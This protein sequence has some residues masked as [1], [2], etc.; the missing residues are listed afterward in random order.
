MPTKIEIKQGTKWNYLTYIKDA[1]SIKIPSGQLFRCGEFKCDCGKIVNVII[2]SVKRGNTKSCGCY[3]LKLKYE[4]GKIINKK[5]NES[6]KNK[7]V[8]Y[9]TWQSMKTRCYN[10]NNPRWNRYGG[11]GIIVCNRWLNSYENF[12]EDMGRRPTDKTS[13]DRINVNGNYEPSNC[14]WSDDLEQAN[15]K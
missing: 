14:R 7:T 2:Q 6:S 11:R 9:I 10:P 15:N 5:H 3:D 12:L 4:R 13:I 1:Q 8:E